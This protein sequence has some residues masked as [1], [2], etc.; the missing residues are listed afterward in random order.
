MSLHLKVTILKCLFKTV[1]T[2]A[3]NI[4]CMPNVNAYNIGNNG[5]QQKFYMDVIICKWE[6]NGLDHYDTQAQATADCMSIGYSL[7]STGYTQNFQTTPTD[8]L[9]MVN[10]YI[11]SS[12][13]C[14]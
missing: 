9:S 1:S 3:V 7:G 14:R 11:K 6:S 12:A 13:C 4:M 8:D 10:K 5:G 2:Q